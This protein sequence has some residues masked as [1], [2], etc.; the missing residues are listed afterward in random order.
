[1]KDLRI[2]PEVDLELEYADGNVRISQETWS[3]VVHED[4]LSSFI[5]VLRGMQEQI[6]EAK[7]KAM[8]LGSV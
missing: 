4:N 7:V 2:K 6:I 1:M 3:L 5:E 8:R